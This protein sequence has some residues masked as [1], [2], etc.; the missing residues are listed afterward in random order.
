MPP[1]GAFISATPEDL[2]ERRAAARDAAID[3]GFFPSAMEYFPATGQ[4][5]PLAASLAKCGRA[6]NPLLTG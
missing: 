2:T 1:R 4:R 6:R 3:A 5:P